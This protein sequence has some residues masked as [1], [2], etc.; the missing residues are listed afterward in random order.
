MPVPALLTA[1]GTPTPNDPLYR[2][3]QGHPKALLPM[4]GK[5]MAQWVLEAL[6]AAQ[7]ISAVVIIGLEPQT[8][9]CAK[10]LF[11]LPDQGTLMKNVVAGVRWIR[12]QTP[13]TTH[14]LLVSSDIPTIT[15]TMVDWNVTTS[16][17]TDHEAYYSVIRQA[18]MERR[19]PHSRRSY[20]K[21]KDGAF[22]A[23]DM[24]LLATRVIEHVP[25][26]MQALVEARKN[27]LRQAQIIGLDLVWQLVWRQLTLN[28]LARTL[29]Q[30]LGVRGRALVCPYP[31]AGMDVDKPEQYALVQRMLSV[32][33]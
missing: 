6:S 16:L 9:E 20:F 26:P 3:T 25:A 8:F 27:F 23:G 28:D 18:D 19:F 7:T 4:A 17:Q 21:L 24:N 5:P 2:Y 33:R 15:S 1:G 29:S 11:Y 22:T 14:T 13:T 30:R 32:R 10:P 12:E 31:E